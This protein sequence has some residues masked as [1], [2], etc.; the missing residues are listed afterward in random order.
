MSA[1]GR[2]RGWGMFRAREE[3]KRGSR[4]RVSL[5]VEPLQ[6]RV[7]PAIVAT[8]FPATG[9]L[10]VI[11][12][13]LDNQIKV[14][15]TAAGS[16]QV[17]EGAVLITGGTPTVAN[18]VQIQLSGLGGHD[19]LELDE[20]NGALPAA[21]LFGGTGNDTLIGG[22][23]ADSLFGQG[24]NDTLFGKSGNDFLFG[25]ASNDVLIGGR[26]NDQVFGEAGNDR[27]IW[28]PGDDTDL[29]EGGEGTD[30]VEVNG[31]NGSETFSLAS[32]GTRVRFD[33]INPA[34]FAIDIGTSEKLVL[35]ANGGDDFVSC[36]GNLS[37]LIQI[38][39][40]GGA[41]NDTI[42]GS[43]GNDTLRGGDGDD[44]IDGNQ[45]TDTAFLGAGNDVFQWDP[46][47]GS[48]FVDGE[49]GF[50]TM[51]FNGSAANEI[52]EL[53]PN[54]TRLRLTRNLG[55]IVMDVKET[56]RVNLEALGGS[57][58]VVV[59]NLSATGVTELN[60]NLAGLLGGATGDAQ[61]D[62]VIVNGL[63]SGEVIDVIGNSGI[64]SVTGLPT[65][66]TLQAVE[67]VDSLVVNAQGGHDRIGAATLATPIKLTL[68]GGA[69]NDTI[70]GS[71]RGDVIVGGPGNDFAD[72]RQGDDLVLLGDGN[73]TFVWNPGDG[74]DTVEGQAG[75]DKMVFN[76]SNA[77]ENFD[78]FA[79]GGRTILFRNVGNITM[80][81]NDL[82]TIELNVL[83]GADRVVLGDLSGTAVTLVDINLAGAGTTTSDGAA[84]TVV[85]NGTNGA[86][87]IV[88]GQSGKHLRVLGLQALVRLTAADPAL[89][90][91]V[92]N[93]LGGDDLVDASA[94][95]AGRITMSLNGGLGND[96]L[97]GSGND[98]IF[99]GGDGDDLILMGAGNDVSIWNPGD[100]NDT[101]EGQGGLDTLVF[102]GSNAAENVDISANGTRVRFFRNVASV[103]M[104]LDDVE[105]IRFNAL[106]GAD[107]VVVND[108]TGTDLTDVQINLGSATNT[109]DAQP[110]TVI[111]NGTGGDDVIL[112]TGS[113]GAATVFGL[114]TRVLI[115][116]AEVSLD[117]L[118]INALAGDDVVEA[119][120]LAA[121][122][123][124]L[125]VDGG[126]GDDVLIGGDGAD[127]L[128]GSAGDDVLMGGPG[129]DVMD[130]GTGNNI[131]IQ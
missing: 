63:N 87:L 68:D 11:G 16:L 119:S 121:N 46:G 32:N 59:G 73:D 80:D 124:G 55:N 100:D 14:S 29:N 131:L 35:N 57:D 90:Q 75:T 99:I 83:G 105:V 31:G 74:S 45:G 26:G 78:L 41:G 18:T 113:A 71:A 95:A 103:L 49:S 53:S 42:L 81:T 21:S 77:S 96:I 79:V 97:L 122:A 108:M 85:V 47:D 54:G 128:L 20:S 1:Q 107:A 10:S 2:S 84:D 37:A 19:L 82:E 110:D 7:M 130:G 93:A 120:G 3:R 86:D 125:V 94:L 12:D 123:I 22:S 88:I 61:P 92:V 101:V 127:T 24:G 39:I 34:P 76:G 67:T 60:V 126:D 102:N 62:T 50:D 13:A 115:E 36:V 43:N 28:N 40:D 114:P 52:F 9:I 6:E 65:L 30:T 106:G 25:G 98:D 129:L 44:F 5:H 8:F 89:D 104:D 56:E 27:M 72:G 38:E 70:I 91:L 48:D 17:N 109:G 33:R 64:V 51:Q 116:K 118:L 15:R 23:G 4:R 69:G 58:T 112:V 66:V 117:R 111:V